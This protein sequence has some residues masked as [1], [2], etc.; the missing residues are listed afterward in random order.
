ML[1]MWLNQ[2]H[3]SPHYM[4]GPITRSEVDDK[5]LPRTQDGSAVRCLVAETEGTPFGYLQWYFN[6]SFPDD[7]AAAAGETDGVSV[8]Y[9]IGHPD[10]LGRGLGVAMLTACR[11]S[12]HAL[13]RQP[14]RRLFIQHSDGNLAA[15]RC[16][17]A[18]GFRLLKDFSRNGDRYLLYHAS[19][20]EA[21]APPDNSSIRRRLS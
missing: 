3:L 16:T 6:R 1:T 18:A 9:Y 11:H 5:F 13:L 20:I 2:P 10:F 8:D 4:Q 19:P 14:D 7:S 12:L 15:R 21:G 17:E